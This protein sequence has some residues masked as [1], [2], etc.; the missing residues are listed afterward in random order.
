[1]IHQEDERMAV[2]DQIDTETIKEDEWGDFE[3]GKLYFL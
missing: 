3:T 2:F 1:M